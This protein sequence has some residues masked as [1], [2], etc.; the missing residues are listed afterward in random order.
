MA[1]NSVIVGTARHDDFI[2]TGFA[3]YRLTQL[4]ESR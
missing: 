4:L 1:V 3:E 2:K